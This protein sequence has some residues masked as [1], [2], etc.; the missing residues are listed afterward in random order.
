VARPTD[1]WLIR[2]ELRESGFHVSFTGRL[3]G[4]RL[5]ESD[6]PTGSSS[7]ART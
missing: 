2:E 7:R 6:L 3:G 1:P 5:D 4:P